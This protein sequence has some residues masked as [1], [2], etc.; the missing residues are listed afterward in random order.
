MRK[1][2]V[3][4]QRDELL[5]ESS[6]R[7]GVVGCHPAN[8]H[9]DIAALRPPELLESIAERR[10][11]GLSFRVALGIPHQR[12]DPPHPLALLRARRER[13]RRRAAEQGDELAPPHSIT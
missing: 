5:G 4:L 13:P 1:K 10:D 11:T 7:L 6:P 2:Q 9:P 3:R 12:A 8:V